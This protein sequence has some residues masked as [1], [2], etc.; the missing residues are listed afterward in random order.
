MGCRGNG[1][2]MEALAQTKRRDKRHGRKRRGG[3]LVSTGT[4]T[5][6]IVC[7]N[8]S[9]K[10]RKLPEKDAETRSADKLNFKSI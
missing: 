7:W 10:K 3:S 4:A 2:V 9:C 6:A 1:Y 5:V 8:K